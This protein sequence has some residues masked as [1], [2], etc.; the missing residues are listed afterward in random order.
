VKLK[1]VYTT[2]E[3]VLKLADNTIP[4][5]IYNGERYIENPAHRANWQN[6]NPAAL[7]NEVSLTDAASG[8]ALTIPESYKYDTSKTV[9]E[10]KT[11]FGNDDNWKTVEGVDVNTV[12]IFSEPYIYFIPKEYSAVEGAKNLQIS[13]KYR[14]ITRWELTETRY[15][16][17]GDVV[18]VHKED[19][20]Y[21]P[22]TVPGVSGLDIG[23]HYESTATLNF[24]LLNNHSYV[25]SIRLGKM[26]KVDYVVED[27]GVEAIHLPVF[28]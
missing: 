7:D 19:S 12:P 13:I 20:S 2:G 21:I 25:V 26:Q 18:N 14:Y 22:A 17:S 15:E 16:I 24:S 4:Y 6:R 28:E 11:F 3:L 9:D 10:L 23:S 27:W 1:N 8:L 5:R